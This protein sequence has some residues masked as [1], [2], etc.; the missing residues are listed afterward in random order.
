M[1]YHHVVTTLLEI[2][3]ISALHTGNKAKGDE[4]MQKNHRKE[5]YIDEK[6]RVN[7]QNDCEKRNIVT[8]IRWSEE[9]RRMADE[10]AKAQNMTRN[11]YMISLLRR[12]ESPVT[13]EMKV[14]IQNAANKAVEE[15]QNG[16]PDAILNFQKEIDAIW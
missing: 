14:K 10:G 7:M 16:N 1:S 8:S 12:A 6:G 3:I 15:I 13:C 5:T 2:I 4:T 11:E 9:E